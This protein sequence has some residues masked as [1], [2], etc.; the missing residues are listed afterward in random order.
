MTDDP[1]SQGAGTAE[2]DPFDE[3]T[4]DFINPEDLVGR[5]VLFIPLTQGVGK[6]QQGPYDYILGDMLILDGPA[7][8]K[9]EGPFPQLVTGQRI[10]AGMMVTQL[11]KNLPTQR[12]ICGRVDSRPG[13]FNRPA[14]SFGSPKPE[15]TALARPIATQWL[16]SRAASSDPF[17]N[18]G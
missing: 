15:D 12:M 1:F 8:K 11:K 10:S 6:G 9:I 2:D 5:L 18:A 17:A 3:A 7:T 4:T 14:Y 16:A 13:Q